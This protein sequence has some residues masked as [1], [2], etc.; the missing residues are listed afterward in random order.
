MIIEGLMDQ[1]P[2]MKDGP[3][4]WSIENLEQRLRHTILKVGEDDEGR[5][6]RIK[7]KYFIDYMRN[8]VDDSP[9]YL[10]ESNLDDNQHIVS[11]RN[12]Y[13]VPEVFPSDF[14]NLAGNE[15]KP[16]FRWFCIGPK[17]SGTTVHKDPLATHA[18]NAV[19]SGKKRWLVAE[20]HYPRSVIKGRS[21]VRK[22]EDDESVHYFD[23]ILPRV[24]A[25]NP[26]F[27]CWEGL[28]GPGE[29]IFVPYDFWHAVVNLEDTVAI[30]QNFCGY[31]N[32]DAVWCKTRKDRKRFAVR[33]L[34]S[35][36]R[37]TPDLYERA[38]FLNQRDGYVMLNERAGQAN[39]KSTSSDSSSSSSDGSTSD[40]DDIDFSGVYLP[41]GCGIVA[42][43]KRDVA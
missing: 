24:K 42:P 33:W 11:L 34:R 22:G 27:K 39:G 6:I 40:E 7:M 14:F 17:R 10:F 5:R 30:T 3:Q 37:H 13:K 20:P 18:W 38:C 12:D 29:V 28:Q 8:Q 41:K 19:T 16:P 1:W 15:S 4:S 21:L 36:K 43:W 35:I 9:M 25:A 23:Y 31:D 26:T 2:A 32:F